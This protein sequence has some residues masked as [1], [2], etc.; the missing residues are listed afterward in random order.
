MPAWVG[1]ARSDSPLLQGL[2]LAALGSA[3]GVWKADTSRERFG[4]ADIVKTDL[5]AVGRVQEWHAVLALI[6][7][8]SRDGSG[9]ALGLGEHSLGANVSFFASTTASKSARS[10]SRS[11]LVR[12]PSRTPRSLPRVLWVVLLRMALWTT[13]QP[14]ALG[15]SGSSWSAA[16]FRMASCSQH[17]ESTFIRRSPRYPSASRRTDGR[18]QAHMACLRAKPIRPRRRRC[19]IDQSWS[20]PS[21]PLGDREARGTAC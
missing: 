7:G 5:L 15:R 21:Q 9:V 16:R 6:A 4:L 3:S 11:R 17:L 1:I 13:L 12:D 14:A 8:C 18:G 20:H 10:A 2:V 19:P